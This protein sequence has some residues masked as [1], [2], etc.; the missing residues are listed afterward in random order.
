MANQANQTGTQTSGE[1][2]GQD[3]ETLPLSLATALGLKESH[4]VTMTAIQ[5]DALPLAL[6]GK[7]VLG[8]AKTGSGKTLSF[9]IPAL[10]RLY[11]SK[12]TALDGLGAL[13]LSPTRELALQ[14]F[15]VLRKIGK[16]H[17]FS[18]GLLIGGKDLKLEQERVGRMNILVCTPGRLLQHMDQTPDFFCDNLQML[19]IFLFFYCDL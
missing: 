17:S 19:G 15:E 1:G 16:H 3:F 11:R 9:L 6:T 4:F 13:I 12:W 18:A 2:L 8:A 7:D 10:E 5:R 14:I